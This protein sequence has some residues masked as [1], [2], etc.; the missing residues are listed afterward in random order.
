M[1]A[2]HRESR[3][4]SSRRGAL[5]RDIDLSQR[6]DGLADGEE[7]LMTWWPALALGRR[8]ATGP[9]EPSLRHGPPGEMLGYLQ[10][11]AGGLRKRLR[12][13]KAVD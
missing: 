11:L 13:N 1:E 2:D 8:A 12:E 7:R 10:R 6:R 5:R 3:G 9:E 4:R